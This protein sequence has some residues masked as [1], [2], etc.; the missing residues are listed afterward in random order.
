M[1]NS[2][3]TK[4]TKKVDNQK[5]SL[6]ADTDVAIIGGALHGSDD[7]AWTTATTSLCACTV[8]RLRE[9]EDAPRASR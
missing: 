2:L 3:K 1:S 8:E 9:C 4:S 7:D 6:L 5:C